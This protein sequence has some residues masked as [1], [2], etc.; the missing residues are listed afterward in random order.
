ML[1]ILEL[2]EFTEM[3]AQIME[4]NHPTIKPMPNVKK[5]MII[6]RTSKIKA[7]GTVAYN[8]PSGPNKNVNIS[9]TTILFSLPTAI[10]FVVDVLS[11]WFTISL[12]M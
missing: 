4:A 8:K 6:V 9:A 11:G 12:P 10:N 1:L 5:P 7:P 2:F 3:T